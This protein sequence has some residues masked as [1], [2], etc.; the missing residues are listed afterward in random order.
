[1]RQRVRFTNKELDLI[2]EMAG[3]AEA[4]A[5]EGDYQDWDT[6]GNYKTLASL[7]DKALDL[8][9]LRRHLTRHGDRGVRQD[10]NPESKRHLRVR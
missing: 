5:P 9:V 4:G 6:N 10:A 1:M 8:Q 3:I 7:T 2:L